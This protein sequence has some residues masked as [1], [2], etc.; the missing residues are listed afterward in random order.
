MFFLH[1]GYHSSGSC[2]A[3]P[4]HCLVHCR[5]YYRPLSTHLPKDLSRWPLSLRITPDITSIGD[6]KLA[7]PDRHVTLMVTLSKLLRLGRLGRGTCPYKQEYE[8]Y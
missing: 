3:P 2:Q 7:S 5:D 4:A 6:A 1:P 8:T